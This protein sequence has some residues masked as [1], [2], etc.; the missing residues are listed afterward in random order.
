MA[1]TAAVQLYLIEQDLLF[2]FLSY[3][4]LLQSRQHPPAPTGE[5]LLLIAPPS[6]VNICHLSG[7]WSR[8]QPHTG[9]EGQSVITYRAS[10]WSRCP[11]ESLGFF[12][13]VEAAELAWRFLPIS[14]AYHTWV[15]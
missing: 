14:L 1:A 12:A 4:P 10:A 2:G 7:R 8:G 11:G 13:G 6:R 15:Q 9:G 5:I 3:Q